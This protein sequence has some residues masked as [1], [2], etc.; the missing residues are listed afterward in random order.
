MIEGIDYAF[1]RPTIPAIVTAG[2][3]FVIR[4]GGA[5][6]SDKWLTAGEA[7]RLRAA[8]LSIVANVEGA[9]S[10]MLG[11]YATG[12]QWASN[13]DRHFRA[14]GMPP[15]RPIYLSADFDV[16]SAQWPAVASALRG[17]A[18]AIGIDR[19]G[20]YGGRNA[21]RWAQR[22]GVARWFWQTYAWSGSPTQWLPGV[23]IQQYRNG[24]TIGG[25][26]CDLDR[27]LTADFG[28]WP[29]SPVPPTDLGSFL[30]ALTPEQQND[31]WEFLALLVDPNTPMTG[32]ASDR[33]HFPPPFLALRDWLSQ[34]EQRDIQ[35]L[36]AAL[37][38]AL[39]I[40]V[41]NVLKRT[42]L[43]VYPKG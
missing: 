33:F 7:D 12:A 41:E 42:G 30:M 5:G 25:A 27:A 20:I 36:A 29:M 43:T 6:T 15:D 3:A 35:A 18:S 19:V 26:D 22:D 13:A 8:G 31:L 32:R 37:E 17:A 40:A 38:P 39:E 34:R 11:G 2:K 9:A 14:C 1:Q 16:Q 28:Q 24:V 23:H 10:G 4:Y 21:I